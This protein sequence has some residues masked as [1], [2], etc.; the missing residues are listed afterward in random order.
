MSSC[1]SPCCVCYEELLCLIAQHAAGLT[2][3]P[4]TSVQGQR[5]P[6]VLRY[7][8]QG[9]DLHKQHSHVH[10]EDVLLVQKVEPASHVQHHLVAPAD[11]VAHPVHLA[12]N[13][14]QAG[15]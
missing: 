3:A 7:D 4:Q 10:V 13:H 9:T 15:G 2:A 6:H 11:T 1:W 8:V 5:H 14:S 12:Q